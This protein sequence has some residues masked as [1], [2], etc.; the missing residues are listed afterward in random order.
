LLNSVN[1]LISLRNISCPITDTFFESGEVAKNM[2]SWLQ[3]RALLCSM[4]NPA[5]LRI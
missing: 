3:E 2:N 5:L 4:Q 1:I